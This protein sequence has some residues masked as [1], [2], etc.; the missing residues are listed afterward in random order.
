MSILV[1]FVA[2]FSA[3]STDSILERM[4]AVAIPDTVDYRMST[5]V[6]GPGIRAS[7]SSHM[8]KAGA[9]RQRMELDAPATRLRIVRNGNRTQMTDLV[10][11]ESKVVP[12]ADGA[13]DM[14]GVLGQLRGRKWSAPRF[15]GND[16]WELSEDMS[17][18]SL[19]SRQSL[20]WSES[21]QQLLSFVRI[22][23]AKDTTTMEFAW[24]RVQGRKVPSLFTIRLRMDG[25][26]TITKVGFTDWSFPKS[27]PSSLFAIP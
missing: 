8:V 9:G 23:R 11:G 7:T 4:A 6:Q 25:R 18:D 17:S 3:P 10:T 20:V 26:E 22:G 15:L 24:M 1:L 2:F 12:S 16:Q 13:E 5:T 19:L 21:E 14:S 27:V